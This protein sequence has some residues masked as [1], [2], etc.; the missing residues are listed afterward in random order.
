MSSTD[1]A[2][3]AAGGAGAGGE[4]AEIEKVLGQAQVNIENYRTSSVNAGSKAQFALFG[5]SASDIGATRPVSKQTPDI[6]KEG[7]IANRNF[8]K[9]LQKIPTNQEKAWLNNIRQFVEEC[10]KQGKVPSKTEILKIISRPINKEEYTHVPGVLRERFSKDHFFALHP[11]AQ[12]SN[13]DAI[14]KSFD[15]N[16]FEE[17][18][19]DQEE[20]DN[21][22]SNPQLLRGVTTY[23]RTGSRIN[24]AVEELT[25][26]SHQGY[27][28][29]QG[30]RVQSW[31]RRF[32]VLQDFCLYYFKT[33][34]D[35][36]ALGVITMPSYKVA[37]VSSSRKWV[38]QATHSNIFILAFAL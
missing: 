29:K 6:S 33:P 11:E 19:K 27:L 15:Q 31:R 2:E 20:D 30:G 9:S 26:P 1:L 35:L 4:D 21:S 24:V 32:C 3:E 8:L 28:S 16:A 34:K 12:K 18:L 22:G 13:L 5:R 10:N 37:A 23:S 7:F 14:S 25:R 17:A 36:T 38:F